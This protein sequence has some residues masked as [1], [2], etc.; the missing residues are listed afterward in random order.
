[1]KN[2]YSEVYWTPLPNV[3]LPPSVVKQFDNK[4]MVV[5][6]W[7]VDIFRDTP[8]GPVPVPCYESYNHHYVAHISGKAA[9]ISVEM[10]STDDET[11]STTHGGPRYVFK[12]NGLSSGLAPTVFC[13]INI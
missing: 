12:D 9:D 7:E 8:N 5:T 2:R 10:P 6:G 1:M 3:P 13:F 4:V 11:A